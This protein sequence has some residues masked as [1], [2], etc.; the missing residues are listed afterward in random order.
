M[1]NQ[2]AQSKIIR[3]F[4]FTNIPGL[5]WYPIRQLGVM[6]NFLDDLGIGLNGSD[7]VSI[8]KLMIGRSVDQFADYQ[9]ECVRKFANHISTLAI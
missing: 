4:M 9:Q 1:L 6:K 7:I 3:D 5:N 8:I 2:K